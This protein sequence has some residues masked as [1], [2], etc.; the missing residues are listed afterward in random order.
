MR[1]SLQVLKFVDH[2]ITSTSDSESVSVRLKGT[3]PRVRENRRM[4]MRIDVGLEF[5]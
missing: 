5:L 1:T 3:C 4:S 2:I